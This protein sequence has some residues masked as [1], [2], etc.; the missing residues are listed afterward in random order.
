MRDADAE[1]LAISGDHIWAHRAFS[2]ALDGLPFPLLAD[3]GMDVTKAY[4]AHNAERNCPTRVAI[5]VDR[6]G[7]VRFVN[8]AFDARDPGH[9]VEVIEQLQA[10]P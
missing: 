7:I 4:G 9:Y 3:W 2:K 5:V 8:T 6:D 10:L 1:L